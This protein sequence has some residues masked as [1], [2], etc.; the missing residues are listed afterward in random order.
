D[1][2]PALSQYAFGGRQ[3]STAAQPPRRA[4]GR[5]RAGTAIANRERPRPGQDRRCVLDRRGRRHAPRRP[6]PGR[7]NRRPDPARAHAQLSGGLIVLLST[8]TRLRGPILS[9][10]ALTVSTLS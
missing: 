8:M 1:R 9:P 5:P 6:R 2:L 3:R 4:T 10:I 7:R